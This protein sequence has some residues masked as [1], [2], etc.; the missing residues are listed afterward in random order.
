MTLDIKSLI[1]AILI[2]FLLFLLFPLWALVGMVGIPVY[3]AL[4]V[5]E[6]FKD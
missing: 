5:Y 3:A 6:D 1:F 2:G 4:K